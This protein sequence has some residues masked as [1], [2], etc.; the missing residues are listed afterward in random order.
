MTQ[1]KGLT[2]LTREIHA[3]REIVSN[4]EHYAQVFQQLLQGKRV[5]GSDAAVV[6]AALANCAHDLQ[7][8]AKRYAHNRSTYA[9]GMTNDATQLLLLLGVPIHPTDG[10][11]WAK[12]GGFG[13][14]SYAEEGPLHK[15]EEAK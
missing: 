3:T 15:P 7:W 13:W 8:Q 1:P 12:D 9:V 14:P 2:A 10:S 4:A 6:V 11:V 5:K